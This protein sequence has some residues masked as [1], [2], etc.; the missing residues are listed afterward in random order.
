MHGRLADVLLY[1]SSE[2]F[3]G[4]NCDIEIKKQD[5]AE[6]SGMTRDSVV[7]VLKRFC[8]DQIIQMNDNH[9]EIVNASKLEEISR[10]G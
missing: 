2:V 7:R 5:L 3:E 6:L 8:T 9:I 1:L 4:I 10:L